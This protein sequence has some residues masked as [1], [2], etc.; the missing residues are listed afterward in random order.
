MAT[1]AAQPGERDEHLAGVGHETRPSRRLQPGVALTSCGHQ[2]AIKVPASGMQQDGR[3]DP[4]QNR[5][6]LGPSQRAP[7]GALAGDESST[8]ERGGH[9]SKPCLPAL[10][11][12]DR[13]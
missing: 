5:A 1:V 4:V 8:I 10:G 6:G 11:G 7:K 2:Q 12:C 13:S 9:D 3:L